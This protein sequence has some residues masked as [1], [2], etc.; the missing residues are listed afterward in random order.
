MDSEQKSKGKK[1][2]GLIL[3]ACIFL[4]MGIG[5]FMGDLTTGM[6]VGMGVGFLFMAAVLLKEKE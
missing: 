4:G 5:K 6:F 3:I 1:I 2:G